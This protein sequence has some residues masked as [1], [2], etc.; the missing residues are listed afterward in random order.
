MQTEERPLSLVVNDVGTAGFSYPTKLDLPSTAKMPIHSFL[1][2]SNANQPDLKMTVNKSTSKNHGSHTHDFGITHSNNQVENGLS[3]TEI[4]D[5]STNSTN[6]LGKESFQ[7]GVLDDTTSSVSHGTERTENMRS[8]EGGILD[9]TTKSSSLYTVENDAGL[10]IEAYIHMEEHSDLRKH[11][12]IDSTNYTTIRSENPG[13]DKLMHAG[14]LPLQFNFFDFN[15]T[16]S[17]FHGRNT[18]AQTGDTPLGSNFSDF[19]V[20]Q[21]DSANIKAN[22]IFANTGKIPLRCDECNFVTAYSGDLRRHKQNHAGEKPYKCE[23]CDFGTT[24]SG[25]LN[26]HRRK[27]TGE[28]PFKCDLCEFRTSQSGHLKKHKLIHT[29]EKPYKCELCDFSA[30]DSGNLTRHKR[31]HTGV[32][33]Y[34]C[35][36]CDMSFNESAG[37]KR[38]KMLHSGEKPFKCDVCD[39]STRHPG[40][41][42]KHNM[43]HTGEISRG[44][45]ET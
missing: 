19:R 28:K 39:F 4:Y 34:K 29:G 40:V 13:I 45:Q 15:A 44:H 17:L 7:Y 3:S 11:K 38:H 2:N 25:V 41:I 9:L 36:M 1:D 31:L 35:D 20:G 23:Y 24:H 37:L 14:D 42:K 33:P 22:E 30:A 5:P 10:H 43:I 16:P 8:E 27:H 26:R 32:R 18:I 21:S 12:S 6:G